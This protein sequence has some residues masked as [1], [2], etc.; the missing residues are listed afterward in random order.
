MKKYPAWLA[1]ALALLTAGT[2]LTG[3]SKGTGQKELKDFRATEPIQTVLHEGSMENLL[4]LMTFLSHWTLFI[5]PICSI[6]I[7][8]KIPPSYFSS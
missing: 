5:L 7:W 1:G 2:L 6:K 3:C 8:T 4:K